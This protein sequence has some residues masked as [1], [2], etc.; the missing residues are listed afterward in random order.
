MPYTT[1]IQVRFRD[2][3]PTRHV[4][5]PSP[6]IRLSILAIVINPLCFLILRPLFHLMMP[7]AED[8]QSW[9]RGAI[10]D[11]QVATVSGTAFGA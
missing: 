4:K 8:N 11:A 9:R 1:E 5:I 7:V 6:A 10:E 3:D 2:F